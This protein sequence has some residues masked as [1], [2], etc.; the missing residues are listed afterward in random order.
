MEDITFTEVEKFLKITRSR[1]GRII[2]ILGKLHPNF[3][4]Y[5][6]TEVGKQILTRDIERMDELLIKI[7]SETSTDLERAEFRHLKKR[8]EEIMG[9]I[10]LYLN[11]VKMIKRAV[12]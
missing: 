2:S 6:N 5:M 12:G 10:E 1:G 8:L 4:T 11:N 9:K 3:D 7:Y